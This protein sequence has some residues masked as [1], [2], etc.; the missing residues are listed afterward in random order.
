MDI[1]RDWNILE[2]DF[3][4][5]YGIALSK[6]DSRLSWREFLVLANGLSPNSVWVLEYQGRNEGSRP[7]EDDDAAESQLAKMGW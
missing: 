4:R 2:A 6:P 5:E 3:R 1:L 7:I